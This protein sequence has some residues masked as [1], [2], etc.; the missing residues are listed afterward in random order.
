M[1]D[2]NGVEFVEICGQVRI[3]TE[4]AILF[5]DGKIEVWVPLSQ[6]EDYEVKDEEVTIMIPEW[7][8]LEKGLI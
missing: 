1:K 7:L 5:Y 8:A 6:L 2:E 3:Q 4:K